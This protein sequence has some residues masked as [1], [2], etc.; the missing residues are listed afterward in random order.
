[1]HR[2]TQP[3]YLASEQKWY[4][5]LGGSI[6]VLS[7]WLL[8]NIAL[9]PV[10]G[11]LLIVIPQSLKNYVQ[12]NIP[13]LLFIICLA[14][15]LQI[16]HR[17]HLSSI[18]TVGRI[19]YRPFFFAFFLWFSLASLMAWIDYLYN[20]P[21]YTFQSQNIKTMLLFLP[22]ALIITGIQAGS[23]ELFFRGYLSRFAY[24][25][26]PH[27]LFY[28]M[29][30]SLLFML[31]HLA[32]PEINQGKTYMLAFYFLFG[33]FLAYLS[34]KQN[35]LEYALGI[36]IANNLFNV[37]ILNY[38]HSALTTPSLFYTTQFSPQN[39]LLYFIIAAFLFLVIVIKGEK[40]GR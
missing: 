7:L 30:P 38:Q 17:Q 14:S 32:N 2:L 29:I 12:V 5:Y 36:H 26:L 16:L 8:L 22:L 11:R 25:I 33:L 1:M 3:S 40:Y 31:V 28:T 27:P 20:Q 6:A 18:I 21:H 34:N 35:S 23:E 39:S 9:L 4:V 15:I 13:F 19:Q 37:L 24:S 10:I